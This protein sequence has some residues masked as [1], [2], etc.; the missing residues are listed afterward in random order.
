MANNKVYNFAPGPAMLPAAVMEKAQ[1]EFLDYHGTGISVVEMS[2]RSREFSEIAEASERD[3]RALLAIPDNFKIMFLQ[4]GATSQFAMVPMN[5][6]AGGKTGDYLHTG[7]WS[8]KGI[9]EAKR[10]GKVHVAASS[11]ADNFMHI[12]DQG[13]WQLSDNPAYLYYCANETIGGV[14]FQW[15][16]DAGDIPLV[17]DMTSN[18]L[19]R[20]FDVS[21]FGV[22][23]AGAQKNLGPAGLVV[24]I[25]REDLIAEPS[26]HLPSLYDY[27][28][29][30]E[31]GS[32]YNT[33][34]TF[35]WY[36]AGLVFKWIK[37]QGG[38]EAMERNSIARSGKLYNA[39]DSSDFYNNPV[40]P[41][42]RSRMNIPFTLADDALN[43]AFLEEAKAVN[44]VELKGH[45]SVGGMR[46]SMY[47]AM[48]QEGCDTLVEFMQEFARRHG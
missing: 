24:V 33:P 48:P 3:L 29:M 43:G 31:S 13:C 38:V 21:R 18:F 15:V 11:K 19:S 35:G 41:E 7:I 17:S 8:G 25:V 44:L 40:A 32:M 37:E 16:P 39:I 12:P 14:E 45:R 27:A 47:N 22:I 42:F 26:E 28:V 6:L 20:P 34:S 30:A 2:H 46:A 23:I 10:H 9:T 1:Q 5:L 36:M 4:G